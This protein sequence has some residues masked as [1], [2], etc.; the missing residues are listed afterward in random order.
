M[1]EV[2]SD[3]VSTP[4]VPINKPVSVWVFIPKSVYESGDISRMRVKVS[5]Q[6]PHHLV[7][8]HGDKV[9]KYRLHERKKTKRRK[10]EP[11]I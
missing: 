4:D 2:D 3:G 8:I 6:F 1:E 5:N 9:K 10:K 7:V 11:S